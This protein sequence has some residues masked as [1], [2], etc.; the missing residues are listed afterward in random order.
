[1]LDIVAASGSNIISDK[2]ANELL[3]AL[4]SFLRPVIQEHA[5]PSCKGIAKR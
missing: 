1:M 2:A 4:V 3:T 5:A